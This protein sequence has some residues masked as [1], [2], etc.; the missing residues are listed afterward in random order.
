MQSHAAKCRPYRLCSHL[1]ALQG[2]GVHPFG[3]GR[4]R[5]KAGL[6]HQADWLASL[7]M[8]SGSPASDH[9]IAAA[10]RRVEKEQVVEKAV[11][12]AVKAAV[13]E[14][15]DVE[16]S[17]HVQT[18]TRRIQGLRDEDGTPNRGTPVTALSPV[19]PLSLVS[20]GEA[21]HL[22]AGRFA[23]AG[24]RRGRAA[25]AYGAVSIAEA[26]A[27]L[28]T[29]EGWGRVFYY[30]F[31]SVE[32]AKEVFQAWQHTARILYHFDP[33]IGLL[34]KEADVNGGASLGLSLPTI[35]TDYHNALKLGYDIERL[36]WPEWLLAE[37]QVAKLLPQRVVAPGTTLGHVGAESSRWLGLP[38]SCRVLAGTT[39]SIA[40]FLAA[41][42]TQ[43]GEAVTSL[44]STLAIKMRSLVRVE[45]AAFGVYS[46]RLGGSPLQWLDPQKEQQLQ[47]WAFHVHISRAASV[48]ARAMSERRK[49]LMLSGWGTGPLEVLCT[50]FS[51]VEFL[52][53]TIPKPP[54]GSAT[55]QSPYCWLFAGTV[56]LCLL[57]LVACDL[58]F[59]S[60][61]A[62]GLRLTAVI[63]AALVMRLCVAGLVHRALQDGKHVVH[64]AIRDF[65]PD[66]LLGFSWGGGLIMWLLAEGD[67]NGPTVLLAPTYRAL[68]RIGCTTLALSNNTWSSVHVFHAL[69]DRYCP[70]VQVQELRAAGCTVHLCD[71]EHILMG[72]QSVLDIA[73]CFRQLLGDS[74]EALWRLF[75]SC[76]PTSR[77]IL[78]CKAG[79]AYLAAGKPTFRLLAAQHSPEALA[80]GGA[81]NTGG[82]VLRKFFTDK[83]LKQLSDEIDPE[84]DSGLDY[85]PLPS[86]GQRFPVCDSTLQPRLEPRPASDAQ[87]LHGI[88][89]GMARI[90]GVLRD[91]GILSAVDERSFCMAAVQ[92][93]PSLHGHGAGG[94]PK[95]DSPSRGAFPHVGDEGVGQPG[96]LHC[97]STATGA[98]ANFAETSGATPT[99]HDFLRKSCSRYLRQLVRHASLMTVFEDWEGCRAFVS[100][101]CAHGVRG[102]LKGVLVGSAWSEQSDPA[103][104]CMAKVW[105]AAGYGKLA[106]LGAGDVCRVVTAGGGAKNSKWRQIRQ[107]L[108][109]VQVQ[110][111]D[112]TEAA[113]GSA[114]LALRGSGL[115]G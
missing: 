30:P 2:L 105:Q 84:A 74:T 36:C 89:E 27:V 75:C 66:L 54:L 103:K 59:A 93:A 87:F 102:L 49:V 62:W 5:A 91:F 60:A 111:A 112:W 19:S 71:D 86:P 92:Q 68:A 10:S 78:R 42:T 47:T 28:V 104:S 46:H 79:E 12:K 43:V 94:A 4:P 32:A 61:A 26:K 77:G 100:V 64:K 113:C 98:R 82:V 37:E 38:V 70:A 90:E 81:S 48:L 73:R 41:G 20:P 16:I 3:S 57:V 22:A 6:V 23:A 55:L 45:D 21:G 31:D 50:H 65:E 72:R 25:D 67:W 11:Q 18:P 40:A 53:P 85:Y 15:Q 17:L 14:L 114:L 51:S 33:T 69:N 1:D 35:R 106:E 109:G 34:I 88:L 58:W 83:A 110:S 39:D 24:L 44:G 115:L 99:S 52:E 7:T 76:L 63:L 9:A 101:S 13:A 95:V 108:I 80:V 8:G 97:E 107:R 29:E 56:I 96:H